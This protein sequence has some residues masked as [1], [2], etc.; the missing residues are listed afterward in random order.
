ML[1]TTWPAITQRIF[2]SLV[3]RPPQSRRTHTQSGMYGTLRRWG[4]G[5][6][7]QSLGADDAA[8]SLLPR[9]GALLHEVRHYLRSS[10]KSSME[11]V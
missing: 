10:G 6:D 7:I 9:V 3:S 5:I 11:R 2:W 4:L 8:A 1:S